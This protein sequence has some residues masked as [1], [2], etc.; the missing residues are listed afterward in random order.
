M[1][2]NEKEKVTAKTLGKV[3]LYVQPGGD[4]SVEQADKLLGTPAKTSIV[5]YVKAGGKYLGICQGAYL[6]GKNPGMGLLSPADTGQYIASKGATTK[7]EADTL[8]PLL[9]NGRKIS[10]YFQDGPYINGNTKNITIMARYSNGLNAA[11]VK[12]FGLGKVAVIGTHPEAPV[13]WYREAGLPIAGRSDNQALG[14][15]LLA[16]VLS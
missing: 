11:G 13:S 7:S 5:N 2:P 14:N 15:A 9:W 12:S 16:K 6:A 3:T 8:V 1:G 10:S 4:T